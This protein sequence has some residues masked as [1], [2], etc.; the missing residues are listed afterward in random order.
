M[1]SAPSKYL[2]KCFC[3]RDYCPVDFVRIGRGEKEKWH[4]LFH[5]Y[6]LLLSKGEVFLFFCFFPP[7]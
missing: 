1:G 2:A 7:K 4:L 5:G 6:H 3:H